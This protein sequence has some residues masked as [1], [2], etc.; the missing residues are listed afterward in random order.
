MAGRLVITDLAVADGTSAR[1]QVGVGVAVEDEQ[2]HW[3]GPTDEADTHGAVVVDGGGATLVPALID[4]HSHLAGPGG[5]HWIERFSDSPE[6]LREVAHHNAH[7]LVQAG[8]LW[9]RDVGAPTVNGRPVNLS[10]RDELQHQMGEPYIRAAGTWLA[11]TGYLPVTID[12]DNG[13]ALLAA[14]M[15]QL[16]AGADFVKIML[17]APGRAETA[18]FSVDEVR[19]VVQAVHA[20]GKIQ[21]LWP[22]TMGDWP[23]GSS[24]R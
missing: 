15:A 9:A 8:I 13:D 11:K 4:A 22:A 23:C 7:R 16:D 1:L 18:P 5:S 2:I 6:R 21:L 17:D 20:R 10:V 3:M 19:R 12:V 14:A 24:S